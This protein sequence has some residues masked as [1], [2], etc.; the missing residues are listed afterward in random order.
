MTLTEIWSN[1]EI[2]RPFLVVDADSNYFLCQS[3][4]NNNFFLGYR[5]EPDPYD[6]RVYRTVKLI[7]VPGSLNVWEVV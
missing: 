5:V 3:I 4:T 2:S 7:L 1:P 6:M